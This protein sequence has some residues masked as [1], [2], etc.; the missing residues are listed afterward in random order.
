MEPSYLLPAVNFT[1]IINEAAPVTFICVVVGIP[2]P[3]ISFYKNGVLLDQSTD[4]RIT[5][6]DNSVPLNFL[7]SNGAVFLVIRI[8]TLDN[9]MDADSGTYT[10]VASNAAANVTRDFELFVQG[11]ELFEPASFWIVHGRTFTKWVSQDTVLSP[12]MCSCTTDH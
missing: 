6:T 9:T 7:T 8:L 11:K 1:E 5:L 3:N 2:A 4:P 10:C 12:S